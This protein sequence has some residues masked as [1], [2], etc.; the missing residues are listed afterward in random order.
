[1]RL[2]LLFKLTLLLSLIGILSSGL[3]GYYAY[4]VNRS[5]LLSEAQTRLL[6]AARSMNRRLELAV[7]DCT[8]DVKFL[9]RLMPV[10]RVITLPDGKPREQAK[11]DLAQAFTAMLALHPEYLQIR[12]I[13]EADNG[14]ELV[15]VDS[16]GGLTLRIEE[17]KLQEKGHFPYVFDTL[18]LPAGQVYQSAIAVN[19]EYGAH[20]AEGRPGLMVAIPVPRADGKPGGLLVINIDLQRILQP[21]RAELPKDSQLYMANKWG[22]FLVHPD[23]A[24]TFGFD[25]GRRI[26]MQDSFPVT[27][28]L[29]ERQASTLT[30]NGLENPQ[31]SGGRVM[32]FVR[33]PFGQ[34][35][36]GDF[37]VTGLVQPLNKVLEAAAPLG[38]SIIHMVLGFSMVGIILA[39]LF[40]R[41]LLRPINALTLAACN[42]SDSRAQQSLPLERKD[43]IGVLARN[44]DSMQRQIRNHM[45]S[46][47]D[48]QREL[49]YLAHHDALTGLANRA[50]FFQQLDAA[51][52]QSTRTGQPFVVLFVDLDHFKQVNDRY[53]HAIGDQ[54]LQIVARRLLHMVRSSDLVARLG[55]D[56]YLVLLQG[57]QGGLALQELIAKLQQN[58]SEPMLVEGEQLQVGASIG[59]SRYPED[60]TTAGQLVNM[61]DHAMY[62]IKTGMSQKLNHPQA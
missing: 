53:G 9:A 12:L 48:N 29:F 22:D 7:D 30:L 13:A 17:G 38:M 6:M 61:A 47:Y 20:D 16:V 54:V 60:G 27:Q 32:A 50:L 43:E 14:L 42:F 35:V 45:A 10:E 33:K 46:L 23:T 57:N 37:V 41:A 44:F 59:C 51:L 34:G 39:V 40:A 55:G 11:T 5:L 56:E 2:G 49:S 21:P 36:Q 18:N 62:Q 31:Q 4:T 15:R 19:H 1:M 24:Q 58:L 26:L 8:D 28:A 25:K 52:L 3:T